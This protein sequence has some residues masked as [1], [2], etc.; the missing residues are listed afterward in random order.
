MKLYMPK[1]P[2]KWGIKCFTL[3]DSA[4]GYVLN[5][6]VYTGRDALEDAGNESLPQPARVVL[7]LAEPYL[8]CGHHMFTDRYY[9][10]LPLAQS[11][12]S[13]Q[14]GFTGTCMKNRTDLP[15][16]VRGQ[17]RLQ[18]GQVA[19]YRADHPSLWLG[20]RKRK[21]SQLSWCLRELP[22]QQQLSSPAAHAPQLSNQWS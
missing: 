17:L 2:T 9:T 4:N 12:H 8:G 13:L 22:Q 6:L 1:K 10:S 20:W 21:R 16:D 14:T 15:D 5:V 18:H 11:L 3:A 19:A 7:H